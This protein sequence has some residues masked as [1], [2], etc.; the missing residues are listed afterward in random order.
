M[1]MKL[2][3]RSEKE[4]VR[5]GMEELREEGSCQG[6]MRG[7]DEGGRREDG[8]KKRDQGG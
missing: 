1:S 4:E 3:G 7:N 5:V 2:R 6:S 8:P